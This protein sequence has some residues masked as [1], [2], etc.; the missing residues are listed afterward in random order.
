MG[1]RAIVEFTLPER[2]RYMFR[3]HQHHLADAG[4]VGWFA[5]V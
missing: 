1:D 2:G 4:A 5:A 3:P